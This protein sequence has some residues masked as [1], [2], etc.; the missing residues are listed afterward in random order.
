MS[1]KSDKVAEALAIEVRE[2]RELNAR[3]LHVIQEHH[4]EALDNDTLIERYKCDQCG[5]AFIHRIGYPWPKPNDGL[6]P[7]CYWENKTK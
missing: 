1:A 7:H 4:I 2:L 3:L 5:G 6:C